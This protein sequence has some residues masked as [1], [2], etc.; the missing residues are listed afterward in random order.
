MLQEIL[1]PKTLVQQPVP[2]YGDHRLIDHHVF[3]NMFYGDPRLVQLLLRPFLSDSSQHVVHHFVNTSFR[4][5]EMSVAFDL[6]ARTN[7]G[8]CFGIILERSY[9]HIDEKMMN[10]AGAA[11]RNFADYGVNGLH[12]P[13]AFLIILSERTFVSDFL[14]LDA[15]FGPGFS[16]NTE[17][18]RV[19]LQNVRHGHP[20][21]ALSHDLLCQDPRQMFY[22]DFRVKLEWLLQDYKYPRA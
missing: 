9:E 6:L 13:K 21:Y 14:I 18:F 19:G 8:T 3:A 16:L 20:L 2:I 15:N 4:G 5:E 10:E 17:G 1:I 7:D 12:H 11:L 22:E